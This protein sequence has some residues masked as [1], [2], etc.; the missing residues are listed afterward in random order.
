[1]KR[2]FTFYR[3]HPGSKAADARLADERLLVAASPTDYV[4]DSHWFRADVDQHFVMQA[5]AAGVDYR[6]RVE[7]TD[8]RIADDGAE[9][10]DRRVGPRRV[11]CATVGDTVGTGTHAN[12]LGNRVQPL[13]GR[14]VGERV[15]ATLSR[16]AVSG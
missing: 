14:P 8:A 11:P 12:A 13:R 6:D 4:S 7:V 16:W 9:I 15:R 5:A 3:H 1:L 10:R 2:G